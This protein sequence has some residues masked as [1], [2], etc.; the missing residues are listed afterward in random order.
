MLIWMFTNLLENVSC[1]ETFSNE[2]PW[3]TFREALA[4]AAKDFRE[5]GIDGWAVGYP[6]AG[7]M[8]LVSFGQQLGFFDHQTVCDLRLAKLL[9]SVASQYLGKLFREGS[10]GQTW[11]QPYMELIYSQFNAPLIPT[12]KRG[13]AFLVNSLELF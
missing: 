12:D 3:V 2:G 11:K 7:F 8:Q 13:P 1:R 10:G 9:H 4:R 5:K 6:V